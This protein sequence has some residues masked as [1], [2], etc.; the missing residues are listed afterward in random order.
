MEHKANLE[1]VYFRHVQRKQYIGKATIVDE[2]QMDE[3]ECVLETSQQVKIL[4]YFYVS[5][6][7][8]KVKMC[9]D[10]FLKEKGL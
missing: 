1:I 5:P 8:M 10:D 4:N 7:A 2:H 9:R 6:S 3:N